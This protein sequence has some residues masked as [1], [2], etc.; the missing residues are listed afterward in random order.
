MKDL[1]K[2]SLKKIQV[3]IHMLIWRNMCK[4]FNIYF[5]N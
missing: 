1:V 5:I 4:K 2:T 3:H